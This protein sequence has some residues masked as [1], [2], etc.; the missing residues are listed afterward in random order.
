MSGLSFSFRVKSFGFPMFG[1]AVS[2]GM[3]ISVAGKGFGCTAGPPCTVN[4]MM[5]PVFAFGRSPPGLGAGALFMRTTL[6]PGARFEKSTRM[7]IRSQIAIS[8]CVS[9][10]GA[11]KKPPSLPICVKD[12][13][14]EKNKL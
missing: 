8:F 6:V 11:G 4:C 9:V 10:T 1:V 7:S 13:P 3:V 2:V 14:F 12:M 5:T